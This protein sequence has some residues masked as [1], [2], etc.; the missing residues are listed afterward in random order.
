MYF[1]DSS[2]YNLS[3]SD[4][5]IQ[6]GRSSGGHSLV[7]RLVGLRDHK[8]QDVAVGVIDQWR[9]A[10]GVVVVKAPK[11]DVGRIRCLVIGDVA[12]DLDQ[13]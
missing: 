10:E 11:L 2:R 8:G 7:G 4:V 12:I 5:S 3:S 13:G 9:D 6:A 1:H